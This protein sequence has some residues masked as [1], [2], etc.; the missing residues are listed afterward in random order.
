MSA[1]KP[2][3]RSIFKFPS[4]PFFVV[5]IIAPLAPWLPYNA[6]ADAPFRTLMLAMSSAFKVLRISPRS[7]APPKAPSLPLPF[8]F[9][10]GRPS[11]T[12][13][14][15]L[16]R[17]D[18]N[19]RSTIFTDPPMPDELRLICTPETLPVRLFMGLTSFTLVSSSPFTT[20]VE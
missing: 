5:I 16:L 19:P 8:V 3:E 15:W 2:L 6:E 4:A 17:F 18:L 9:V 1:V 11:M 12:Y 13:K 14:G 7:V 10:I 20:C